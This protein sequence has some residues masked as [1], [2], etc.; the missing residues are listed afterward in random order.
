MKKL[1]TVLFTIITLTFL[2]STNA[3]AA[4]YTLEPIPN[5]YFFKNAIKEASFSYAKDDINRTIEEIKYQLLDINKETLILN[6]LKDRAISDSLLKEYNL[7][8]SFS[9]YANY[10]NLES[11][12]TISIVVSYTGFYDCR[13]LTDPQEPSI[14]HFTYSCD[15]YNPSRYDDF[16]KMKERNDYIGQLTISAVLG[17][18][19]SVYDITSPYQFAEE[20]VEC[21]KNHLSNKDIWRLYGHIHMNAYAGNP[22]IIAFRSIFNSN[23]LIKES[24]NKDPGYRGKLNMLK[25][26][27]FSNP[28]IRKS[29]FLDNREL[30]STC[31]KYMTPA[32]I[33]EEAKEIPKQ[34]ALNL[35]APNTG[36]QKNSNIEI[37][38]GVCGISIIGA[39]FFINRQKIFHQ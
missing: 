6:K 36:I 7:K 19:I 4:T 20:T 24:L 21:T 5:S 33:P 11:E 16:M 23:D 38:L 34:K 25:Y 26:I 14:K 17:D 22:Y 18:E 32:S 9:V 12:K 10:K 31:K 35:N 8:P 1:S 37:L 13:G 27:A 15:S 29:L 28:T 3:S 39:I 30:Y 2:A